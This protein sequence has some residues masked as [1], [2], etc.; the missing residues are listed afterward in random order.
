MWGDRKKEDS[1]IEI[2]REKEEK[3]DFCGNSSESDLIITQAKFWVPTRKI[4]KMYSFI[5]NKK[6]GIV[7]YCLI[8]AFSVSVKEKPSFFMYLAKE[9]IFQE[10][11]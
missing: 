7:M 4:S 9:G 1:T 3:S 10:G 8:C 2:F 11:K 6:S 5:I